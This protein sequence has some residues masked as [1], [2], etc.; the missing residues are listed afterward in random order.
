MR[1]E[2]YKGKEMKWITREH[3]KVDRVACPWLIRKFV[4]PSAEFYFVPAEQ[5]MSAAQRLCPTPFDVPD[6]HRG[7]HGKACSFGALLQR[8]RPTGVAAL[9][10]V[11][12]IVVGAG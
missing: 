2:D 8:Y 5:V 7:H 10:L 4:D 1:G 3:V 6:V 9:V 12:K 11:G